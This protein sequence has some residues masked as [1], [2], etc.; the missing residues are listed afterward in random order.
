[1]AH[2]YYIYDIF[3]FSASN[4]LKGQSSDDIRQA[5]GIQEVLKCLDSNNPQILHAAARLLTNLEQSGS[6][7]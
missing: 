7:R 6:K 4:S 5:G 3:H 1:M 2:I